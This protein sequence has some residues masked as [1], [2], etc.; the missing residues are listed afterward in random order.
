MV[1]SLAKRDK[2]RTRK[3]VDK[4]KA[5]PIMEATKHKYVLGCPQKFHYWGSL[6]FCEML[7][8]LDTITERKRL[9][10]DCNICLLCLCPGHRQTICRASISCTW[11][12]PNHNRHNTILCSF[13]SEAKI[14]QKLRTRDG[15]MAY[16]LHCQFPIFSLN[17]VYE[18]KEMEQAEANLN[19][20]KVEDEEESDNH[21]RRS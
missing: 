15:K 20:L 4:Y 17:C 13:T 16:L 2:E 11:C 18:D 6:C 10:F 12:P 19:N 8:D 7:L 14:L 5:R 9:C 3:I 1:S 21:A